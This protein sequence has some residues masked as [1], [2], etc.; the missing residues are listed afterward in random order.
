MT[1]YSS[2]WGVGGGGGGVNCMFMSRMSA[3]S[4]RLYTHLPT[5]VFLSFS[6]TGRVNTYR[7]SDSPR[8]CEGKRIRLAP[9][10]QALFRAA[11]FWYYK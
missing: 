8:F 4:C 11:C 5:A 6:F 1:E 3:D 9:V 2:G 7:L 10:C